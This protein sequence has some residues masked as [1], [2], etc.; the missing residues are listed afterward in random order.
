MDGKTQTRWSP[1]LSCCCSGPASPRKRTT[2]GSSCPA[3]RK[4]GSPVWRRGPSWFPASPDPS[5]GPRTAACWENWPTG[6]RRWR[7]KATPWYPASAALDASGDGGGAG[8]STPSAES[9][10]LAAASRSYLL[11]SQA[12]LS[13]LILQVCLHVL[14]CLQSA[15]GLRRI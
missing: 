11:C 13:Q 7:W 2:G 10:Q 14:H 9:S 4:P 6:W 12:G 1:H 8:V 15:A 5:G 3:G